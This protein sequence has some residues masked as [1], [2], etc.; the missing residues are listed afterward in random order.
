MEVH[1]Y[2]WTSLV[3][4]PTCGIHNLAIGSCAASFLVEAPSNKSVSRGDP[5]LDAK[6][7][8]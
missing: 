6:A 5:E 1:A 3:G 2:V 4:N 8:F 7:S